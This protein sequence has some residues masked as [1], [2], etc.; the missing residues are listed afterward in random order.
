[1]A[2]V[3]CRY[4]GRSLAARTGTAIA[5]IYPGNL[6]GINQALNETAEVSKVVPG[7]HALEA[8]Y[9]GVRFPFRI[10]QDGECIWQEQQPT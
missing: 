8:V 7:P 1:M 6:K 5:T 4:L 10:Y 9:D 3:A 2:K